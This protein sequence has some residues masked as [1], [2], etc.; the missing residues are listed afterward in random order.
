[1]RSPVT[2]LILLLCSLLA[3]CLVDDLK[4]QPNNMAGKPG[5]SVDEHHFYVSGRIVKGVFEGANVRVYPIVGGQQVLESVAESVTDARGFYQVQIPRE[6]FGKSALIRASTAGARM[7]CDLIKGCGQQNFGSWVLFEDESLVIDIGV[8]ELR[9]RGIYNGSV[10][11]HIGFA[12]AKA[13]LPESG[14]PA[15]GIADAATKLAISRANSEV[16]SAFGVIGDL[17]S[18]NVVDVTDP[19]DRAS[20]DFAALHYSLINSVAVATA[21]D[22]YAEPDF[23]QVLVKLTSQFVKSGIPGNLITGAEEVTQTS[24]LEALAGSYVYLGGLDGNAYS[25]IQSEI[26][27]LRGLYLNEPLQEYGRGVSSDNFHLTF[28]EKAKQMVRGVRDVA[29]SLDLRKLVNINN[30]SGLLSGEVSGALSAFGVVV[31]T[32][33]VLKDE[34]IDRIQ[35]ALEAISKAT[36]DTLLFYY[37]N[38]PKPP[39]LHGVNIT[40][41]PESNSHRFMIRDSIDICGDENIGNDP[42]EVPVDLALFLEFDSFGG[43]TSVSSIRIDNLRVSILGTIGDA[44]YRLIFSGSEPQFVAGVL[45]IEDESDVNFSRTFLEVRDWWMSLPISVFAEDQGSQSSLNGTLHSTGEELVIRF[46]SEDVSVYESDSVAE[47]VSNRLY[48]LSHLRRF[49]L[50]A[51]FSVDVT[52]EDR[53]SASIDF[54][55]GITPFDGKAVYRMSSRN[56]CGAEHNGCVVLED[57]SGIEGETADSF[58]QLSASAAYKANLKA[59]EAPVMIQ[60]SGSR[61]SP[62]TNRVSSLKVSYPGHALALKGRF[63]NNGGIIA[64]DAVNLDGMHLHFDTINGKRTGKVETPAQESVAEIIDMGQWV[65]VRYL[66]G[67][68]ES[69]L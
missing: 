28:L 47:F 25:E 20:A 42:C 4:G 40:H 53:F 33:L 51:A 13:R 67:Y 48:E 30:L 39:L 41:Y 18:L 64:L 1:M 22:V 37:Q 23:A 24:L 31:D 34:K 45:F 44:G 19:D 35:L 61:D 11:T 52:G 7:K 3:G 5:D 66:D 15:N 57:E 43:N 59:V 54:T 27:A 32:S 69:L 6:Y 68:F 26:L 9:E 65:K 21:I 38:T 16:A 46:E 49:N 50:N 55:Q 36:F 63:N 10:L 17:P 14:V 12:V 2:F 8:P 62:T 60:M 58:V 56:A 29:L